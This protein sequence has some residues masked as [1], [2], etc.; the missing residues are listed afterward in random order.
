MLPGAMVSSAGIPLSVAATSGTRNV[1][2]VCCGMKNSE[3]Q[4]VT[5][6]DPSRRP[7]GRSASA[8]PSGPSHARRRA[9]I[10]RAPAARPLSPAGPRRRRRPRGRCG[11]SSRS[12]RR[13]CSARSRAAA[14]HLR[15]LLAQIVRRL[16]CRPRGELAVLEFG[17][18]A[19]RTDRAMGMNGEIIGGVELLQRR[20]CSSPR[21]H[22]RHCA[23]TSS[24]AT[25]EARTC[26]NSFACS[27]KPS[28]ADQ[29]ALSCC[30]ALIAAH[31]FSATTPRKLPSRTI[32]HDAGDA[33]RPMLHRRFRA[34][35]RWPA[36][37]RRAHAACRARGSP[38]CR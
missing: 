14:E 19:G 34:W 33:L 3:S 36:A 1:F 2:G 9:T 32:L 20:P 31:S 23:V 26:S 7:A 17:D 38:A 25:L 24:L 8:G 15:Q 35:R 10:A 5:V 16:R 13:R 37:A 30:A 12:P 4:A 6:P 22:C 11:H 29:V 18:R 27:G 21:R 28:H